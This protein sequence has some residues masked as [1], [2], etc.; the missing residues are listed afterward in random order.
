[1]LNQSASSQGPDDERG[2]GQGDTD[3]DWSHHL[4][5]EVGDLKQIQSPGEKQNF[6]FQFMLHAGFHFK[7]VTIRFLF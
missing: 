4:V 6:N 1:V 3:P 5:N 7:Y 2:D